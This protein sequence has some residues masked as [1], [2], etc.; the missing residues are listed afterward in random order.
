MEKDM[1]WE[2]NIIIIMDQLQLKQKLQ[3]KKENLIFVVKLNLKENI[4]ME[5]D[6]MEKYINQIFQII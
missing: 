5:K 6:G 4:W 2:L 3:A 1:G